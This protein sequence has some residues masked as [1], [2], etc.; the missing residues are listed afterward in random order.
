MSQG[1]YPLCLS[2]TLHQLHPVADVFN[3][4]IYK[5]IDPCC[6]HKLG[7]TSLKSMATSCQQSRKTVQALAT[8]FGAPARFITDLLDNKQARI[9]GKEGKP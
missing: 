6:M 2:H 7:G 4:L 3:K 5:S 1:H 8:A 9:E